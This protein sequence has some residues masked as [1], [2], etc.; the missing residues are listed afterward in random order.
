MK[1]ISSRKALQAVVQTA[2]TE[3]SRQDRSVRARRGAA[4]RKKVNAAGNSRRRAYGYIR[5][6]TMQDDLSDAALRAQEIEIRSY[7]EAGG[8]ELLGLFT[9]VAC[10]GTDRTRPEFDRMLAQATSGPKQVDAII[11]CDQTRLTRDIDRARE[12]ETRLAR[13]GV[14]CLFV[15]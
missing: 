3:I 9:D 5:A 8:I 15:R 13:A 14:Q 6:N 4:M 10:S 12:T 11:V 1:T 7:C 2:M